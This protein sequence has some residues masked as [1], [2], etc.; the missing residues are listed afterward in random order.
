[1]ELLQKLKLKMIFKKDNELLC[2]NYR[3]IS[4]L[5]I[6]S[7][8]IEKVIYTRMYEFLSKNNLIYNRQFGF[9]KKHSTN[10]ALNLVWM[11]VFSQQVF[12]Y[13]LKKHLILFITMFLIKLVS[14]RSRDLRLSAY[15]HYQN[16]LAQ[17]QKSKTKICP[18]PIYIAIGFNKVK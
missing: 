8:I 16:I 3:P 9:R 12:L 11:K 17:E 5:P 15:A 7:K 10:H 13:I 4:L 18:L 1:M 14:C 6:F 2:E